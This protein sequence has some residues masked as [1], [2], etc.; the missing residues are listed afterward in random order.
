MKRTILASTLALTVA[1]AG[2]AFAQ[3]VTTSTTTTTRTVELTP[4]QR[5]VFHDYVVKDTR[6]SFAVQGFDVRTGAV[7]PPNVT[8]YD[9]PNVERYRYTYVNNHR[10]IVDPQTREVVEVIQ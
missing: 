8:F 2:A 5:T 9:V 7:L 6:P 4:D 1:F 10:V 3:N